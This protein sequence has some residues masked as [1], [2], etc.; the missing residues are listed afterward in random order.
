MIM[1]GFSA[2]GLPDE[3]LVRGKINER[4]GHLKIALH[5]S[6]EV[7]RRLITETFVLAPDFQATFIGSNCSR[8]SS[9][10][11]VCIKPTP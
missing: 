10:N 5:V 11:V 8:S 4:F 7:P 3:A 9:F 1:D 2:S 6:C